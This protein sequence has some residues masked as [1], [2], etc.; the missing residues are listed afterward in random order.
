MTQFLMAEAPKDRGWGAQVLAARGASY[1]LGNDLTA[2][3]IFNQILLQLY[4]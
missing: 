4:E 1:S 2:L 3:V